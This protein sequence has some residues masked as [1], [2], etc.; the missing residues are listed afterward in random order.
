[1]AGED[2]DLLSSF[3]GLGIN[4]EDNNPALAFQ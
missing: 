3:L 1:M 4:S 2:C